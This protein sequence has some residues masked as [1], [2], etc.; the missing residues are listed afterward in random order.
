MVYSTVLLSPTT[1]MTKKKGD[2]VS[3]F[4]IHRDEGNG[5]EDD[6]LTN[7]EKKVEET[8]YIIHCIHS[9]LNPK[10]RRVCSIWCQINLSKDFEIY[11]FSIIHDFRDLFK[12]WMTS[13]ASMILSII[14]IPSNL[15]SLLLVSH[16]L[17]LWWWFCKWNC[18]VQCDDFFLDF[19]GFSPFIT[20]VRKISLN[21]CSIEPVILESSTI[22]QT[23]SL[24]SS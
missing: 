6:A 12:E 17:S 15:L 22:F 24:I 1:I 4:I 21:A 23:Y 10:S 2:T 8:N 20:K 16:F 9:W 5:V 18:Q 19:V 14:C 7:M 11:S 3:T 13:W